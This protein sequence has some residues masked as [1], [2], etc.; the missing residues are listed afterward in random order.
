MEMSKKMIKDIVVIGA[1]PCGAGITKA[2]VAE[3]VFRSIKVIEK[4]A[5]TGGLWNYTKQE[6]T[7]PVPSEDPKTSTIAVTASDNDLE[8]RKHYY[9][10]I[11]DSD[12]AKRHGKEYTWPSA[13]YD[14]L[15]TNVPYD[16]MAYKD[17]PWPS[18]VPLFPKREQVLQYVQNYSKPIEKY[19]QF[20]FKVVDVSELEDGKFKVTSRPVVEATNAALEPST[21]P[22]YLDHVDIA[23]LVAVATGYYDVPY[24]PFR[25]GLAEWHAKYPGSVIHAKQYK[26]PENYRDEKNI[27]I[28]GNS[29]SGADLAYQLATVLD[30][31]IYKSVRSANNLPLGKDERI[32]DVADILKFNCETG[33][34]ELV[35]GTTIPDVTKII[36]ATGYLK[37]L[38]FFKDI[39]E[40]DHP[41]ISDGQMVHG[42]W[43][44]VLSIY[45]PGIAVIGLPRFVLPTRLSET[46]GAWL[47]RAWSGRIPLPSKEEMVEWEKKRLE[48]CGN[49]KSFHD[50]KFPDDVIYSNKLNEEIREA[51][52]DHG[53]F[54]VE[55]DEY[56]TRIRA[57]IKTIK[58]SYISYKARTGKLAYSLQELMD[59]NGLVLD[60]LDEHNFDQEV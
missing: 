15:D 32:V 27:L 3:G 44:Q 55:W 12:H 51:G 60:D 19:V 38:P 10:N 53:Y 59:E 9:A 23:D 6:G 34:V 26:S 8:L 35:D 21:D 17:S 16:L 31:K 28:V 45:H 14:L 29:A 18:N 25:E 40:S 37:S 24:V 47:A 57:S 58:E 52:T 13:V 46:Q 5:H 48:K 54:P 50:L 39:N 36:F 30:K 1:G 20:G 2:L 49:S 4:R 56:Q 7:H 41:L 33:L 22:Q 42:L 43:R 11:A